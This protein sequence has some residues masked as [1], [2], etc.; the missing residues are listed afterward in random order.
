M[1]RFNNPN[2]MNFEDKFDEYNLKNYGLIGIFAKTGKYHDD[3]PPSFETLYRQE[4]E[5]QKQRARTALFIELKSL[6]DLRE[7]FFLEHPDLREPPAEDEQPAADPAQQ[8]DADNNNAAADQEDQD[9][10]D[11]LDSTIPIDPEEDPRFRRFPRP[12]HQ[13]QSEDDIPL[14]VISFTD[15]MS[16]EAMHRARTLEEDLLKEHLKKRDKVANKRAEIYAN[17]W[18]NIDLRF[19]EA[20]RRDPDFEAIDAEKNPLKLWRIVKEIATSPL[21]VINNPL[22][23]MEVLRSY[24]SCKQGSSTLEYYFRLFKFRLNAAIAA[25]FSCGDEQEQAN[26]FFEG[27]D[28]ARFGV[29]KSNVLHGLHPTPHSVQE[30]YS[31]ALNF[32]EIKKRGSQYTDYAPPTSEE[33]ALPVTG[34]QSQKKKG[35][36]QRSHSPGTVKAHAR[37][38]VT[39]ASGGVATPAATSRSSLAHPATSAT[40]DF[41]LAPCRH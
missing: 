37:A 6:L 30:V 29:F 17:L 5:K 4:R 28:N 13:I 10:A 22:L 27:L 16:T 9:D 2:L 35:K 3:S 34:E 8:P 31:A 18:S 39:A 38:T 40:P 11:S 12:L 19:Q 26:R 32:E 1:L 14:N 21:T 15:A 7:E 24:E 20:V 36:K 25:H 23:H 33:I 41:N